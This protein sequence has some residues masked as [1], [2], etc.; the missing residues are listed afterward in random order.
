VHRLGG[1]LALDDDVGLFEP[2]LDVTALELDVGGDVAP[3]GRSVP[4]GGLV[5][6]AVP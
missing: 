1:Q 5:A 3:D 4:A 2:L 6:A